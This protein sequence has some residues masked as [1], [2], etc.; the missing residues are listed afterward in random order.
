LIKVLKS[1]KINFVIFFLLQGFVIIDQKLFYFVLG[2]R[3]GSLIG[4]KNILIF[5]AVLL[6]IGSVSAQQ[7]FA[8]TVFFQESPDQFGGWLNENLETGRIANDF[9]SGSTTVLTD[10][11]FW[12]FLFPPF[13]GEDF[14]TGD[15]EW[16]IYE[17]DGGTPGAPGALVATGF[18][19]EVGKELTGF[20]FQGIVEYHWWMDVVPSVPLETD[21][22][23]WVALRI[24]QTQ[25]SHFWETSADIFGNP[26][27]LASDDGDDWFDFSGGDLA[28]Q[29]TTDIPIGGT[30]G[31]LDT[32]TLLVAGAQ[33][34]MGLWSLALVG[35]VGAGA[36]ITYKL[37]SKKTEQ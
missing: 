14:S 31:S 16:W 5:S 23:Y 35:I 2:D 10:I 26:D 20:V 34:N 36:A 22:T 30:V 15:V 21:T 33:A 13:T 1:K 4:L 28:F 3:M 32:A 19:V 8:D 11:H 25:N 12:T 27:F 9:P 6:A 7:A 24:V 18:G 29:L 37:K 17:D